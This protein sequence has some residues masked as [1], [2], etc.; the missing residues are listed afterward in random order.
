MNWG[1]VC[2]VKERGHDLRANQIVIVLA[3][4]VNKSIGWK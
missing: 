3:D 1:Q 2:I 4:L